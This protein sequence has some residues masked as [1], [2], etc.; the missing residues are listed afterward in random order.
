MVD[1]KRKK[2]ESFESLLRRFSRRL[3]QSGKQLEVRKLR[4]RASKPNK[5]KQRESALRRI[6]IR[7]KRE[8]LA[9]IGQL[10]EEVR[11][12]SRGR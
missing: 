12:P 1:V 7:E 8:Y 9:R 2:G 11:Q 4:Y 3:Q 10:K 6:E 5:N